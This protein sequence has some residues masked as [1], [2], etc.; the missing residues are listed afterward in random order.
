MKLNSKILILIFSLLYLSG[1][2]ELDSTGDTYIRNNLNIKESKK[3]ITIAVND[4]L[5]KIIEDSMKTNIINYPNSSYD[6][7]PNTDKSEKS[8][9]LHILKLHKLDINT[10]YDPGEPDPDR[11]GNLPGGRPI[12]S[13][14]YGG[15]GTGNG[16][17]ATKISPFGNGDII[18]YHLRGKIGLFIPYPV[19]MQKTIVT[20]KLKNFKFKGLVSIIGRDKN[21]HHSGVFVII[22]GVKSNYSTN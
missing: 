19:P 6:I 7:I 12:P 13:V 4:F 1:C 9:N 5:G 8:S 16:M 15:D 22:K 20:F 18:L 3:Y 2:G 11:W 21:G 10:N 17:P 14:N